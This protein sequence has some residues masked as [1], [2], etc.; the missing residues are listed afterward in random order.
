M[1]YN[2]HKMFRL[3]HIKRGEGVDCLL[4]KGLTSQ[5]TE[6]AEAFFLPAVKLPKGSEIYKNGFLGVIVSGTAKLKR[7]NDFG[8]SV[9][10]R[11]LTANEIFGSASVFGSLKEGSSSIIADR[12]C[13]CSYIS[14]QNLRALLTEIPKT[15]VNYIEFLTEKIRFLN[16]RVDTFSADCAEQRIY[17]FLLSVSDENGK[18]EP[19]VNL[20][21]LARRLKIGRTSLYRCLN[22]LEDGGLITREGKIFYVK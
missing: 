12:T 11:T 3:V 13:V 1:V 19:S 5:E 21:E 8:G 22:S 2:N 18:A 4:F 9:T 16:R 15:A 14:E 17:E 10:V 7:K 6:K 20:A